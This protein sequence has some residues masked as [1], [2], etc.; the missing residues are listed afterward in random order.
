MKTVKTLFVI[1]FSVFSMTAHSQSLIV[2]AKEAQVYDDANNS[3]PTM[4]NNDENIILKPGMVFQ[5]TGNKNGWDKIVYT[6]GL[7]GYILQGL[8]TPESNLGTPSPGT[9]SVANSGETLTISEKDKGIWEAKGEK[10]IFTG[11]QYGKIIIFKD[12]FTNPVFSFVVV[13][14]NPIIMSYDND[15]TK[16]F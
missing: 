14:S 3:Y 8:E 4:N 5:K 2:M 11:N 6:P 7:S 12:K 13:N 1:L 10:G 9:Y 15:I 16:F